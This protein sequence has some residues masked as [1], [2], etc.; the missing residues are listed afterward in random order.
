MKRTAIALALVIM[1]GASLSTA[2]AK[3]KKK[4][5][6]KAGTE[7]Q[8]QPVKLSSL[9]D[10]VSYA[11]GKLLTQGMMDYVVSQLKLDTAYMA[12]FVGALKENLG[13]EDTPQNTA[14]NAGMHI[15]HLIRTSMLAR[16]SQQFNDAG[17]PLDTCLLKRG[18]IDAV[19]NDTTCF[20]VDEA[21]KFQNGQM[22]KQQKL[23]AEKKRA[24]GKAWLEEN[25]KQPGVNTTISGLQYRVI[26][27]G[28]GPVAVADENVTV[29]Y[30]G[31]LI[32]GT[33]FDSSYTRNPQTVTFKPSQV[34]KGWTE[35]LHMM[36]EGSEWEI[37]V[38]EHIGYGERAMGNIPPYSTLIFKME[39]VKVEKEQPAKTEQETK[40][41][42]K[43]TD[44]K[45]SSAK[46][47][48]ARK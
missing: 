11:T 22:Q 16:V 14:R 27:Q 17:L 24:A 4:K 9:N 32:D 40:A 42:A 10:S 21:I 18:F 20:T 44:A 41:G 45:K 30:E 31:R 43:K 33:V 6:E 38:P 23:Q 15:A 2:V 13:A 19:S 46:K 7:L 8:I 37:Y 35:A 3:E 48:S 47:T 12:D 34:I 36:P 28:D 29:K 25:A 1:A 39:I 5:N 26:K